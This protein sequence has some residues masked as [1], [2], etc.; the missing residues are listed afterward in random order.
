MGREEPSGS[1]SP[2]M[3]EGGGAQVVSGPGWGGLSCP[4]QVV[5]DLHE[6]TIE[7]QAEREREM[8]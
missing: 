2:I 8:F 7:K 5:N 1:Q 4:C 3:D 6:F